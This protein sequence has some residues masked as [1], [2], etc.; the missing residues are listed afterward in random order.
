VTSPAP[1]RTLY[2]IVCGAGS[3]PHAGRFVVAAQERGWDVHVI[4]TPAALDFVD[5]ASLEEL[6]GHPVRSAYRTSGDGR[7][8]SLPHASAIVV[9]PATY[10]TINKWANGTSDTYAL[11]ILA[12]SLGLGIPVVVLPFVNS[13]LAAHFAF[14]RS[15]RELRA[16]GVRVLMGPGEWEP[17]PPGTGGERLDSF[18]WHLALDAAERLAGHPNALPSADF[19]ADEGS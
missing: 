18:P 11:G 9:A 7:R 2:L 8:A 12:E 5:V 17:H 15:V 13:A 19:S 3:A 16:A 6:S 4:A 14:A 10:N 1:H